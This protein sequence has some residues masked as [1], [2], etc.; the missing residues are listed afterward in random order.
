LAA[1]LRL[2]AFGESHKAFSQLGEHLPL[3][4]CCQSIMCF[5]D[6]TLE[7]VTLYPG[8]GNDGTFVKV[9]DGS[10]ETRYCRDTRPLYEL[11]RHYGPNSEYGHG[12]PDDF[13]VLFVPAVER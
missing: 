7:G 6:G 13:Q 3:L 10:V 11:E 8:P 12:A 2:F 5:A 9:I 1:L 4:T